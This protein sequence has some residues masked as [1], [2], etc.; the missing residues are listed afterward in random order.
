[1]PREVWRYAVKRL[2]VADLGNADRLAR[3]GLAM[4]GPGRP[5]IDPPIVPTGM[6]T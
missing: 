1:L 2:V 3:V 5:V 6:R 4:P